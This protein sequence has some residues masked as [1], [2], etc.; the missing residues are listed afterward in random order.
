M[1][2]LGQHNHPLSRKVEASY[3]AGF[4]APDP[5]S[6]LACYDAMPRAVRQALDE[7]PWDIS[8]VAAYHHLRTHGLASV[9]REIHESATAFYAAFERET[10]VPRPMKPIGRGMGKKS[11]R[12]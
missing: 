11:F 9:L 2:H 5:E 7:A 8:A 6:D 1:S 10:G 3:G 4:V 12:R